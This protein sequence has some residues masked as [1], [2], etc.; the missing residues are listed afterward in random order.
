MNGSVTMEQRSEARHHMIKIVE[1][2]FDSSALQAAVLDLSDTGVRVYFPSP[3]DIPDVVVLRLPGGAYRT[4]CCKWRQGDE[5]GFEFL[6]TA[7]A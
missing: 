3:V 6:P 4:A 7:P 5:A 2:L 1:V